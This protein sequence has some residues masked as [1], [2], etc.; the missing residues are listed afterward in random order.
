MKARVIKSWIKKVNTISTVSTINTIK[1]KKLKR[2]RRL[3]TEAY[4][5]Y[6]PKMLN[7]GVNPADPLDNKEFLKSPKSIYD[8]EE[9][10]QA[11][12]GPSARTLGG[13]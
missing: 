3:D 5:R 1:C 11:L 13:C 6:A 2:G 4:S 8:S 9:A 12:R 7:S 10:R